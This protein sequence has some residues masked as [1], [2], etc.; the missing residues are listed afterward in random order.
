LVWNED[1]IFEV[2][3]PKRWYNVKFGVITVVTTKSTVCCVRSFCASVRHRFFRK[4]I[5]SIILESKCK[6]SQY[7][8]EQTLPSVYWFPAWIT[9]APCR[10][11]RR[12]SPKCRAL[13][14][15]VGIAAGYRLEAGERS[16][17]LWGPQ[18]LLTDRYGGGRGVIL[19]THLHLMSRFSVVELY[20]HCPRQNGD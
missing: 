18:N 6:P 17:R 2:L 4:T 10:Q 8:T 20:I 14:E 11:K 12:V 16:E 19:T 13:T 9:L 7:P 15:L 5:L 3:M 1:I